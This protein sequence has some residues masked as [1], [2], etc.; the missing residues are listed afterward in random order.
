M[1]YYPPLSPD[2]TR[3][4]HIA[5]HL[6][7]NMPYWVIPNT[8]L[9]VTARFACTISAN[10][11]VPSDYW[12][13]FDRWYLDENGMLGEKTTIWH[14]PPSPICAHKTVSA[15]KKSHH[16]HRCVILCRSPF[17]A[18]TYSTTLQLYSVPRNSSKRTMGL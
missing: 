17:S 7:R 5:P 11:I 14:V 9:N 1:F 6:G 2:Q 10:E 4:M 12:E 3:N 16:P 15:W 8:E 18:V 13:K